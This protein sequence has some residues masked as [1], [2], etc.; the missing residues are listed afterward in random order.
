[1]SIKVN[2]NIITGEIIGFYSDGITYASI[3]E[4]YI[5]TDYQAYQDCLNNQGLRRVDIETKTIIEYT[6]PEPAPVIIT[7][8]VNQDLAD[9][10]EAIFALSSEKGGE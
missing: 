5:E 3:P 6:P 1:M 2:Y 7:P 8:S 4:P 9:V 10:W